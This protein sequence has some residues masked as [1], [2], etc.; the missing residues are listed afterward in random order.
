[1]CYGRVVYNFPRL[2]PPVRSPRFVVTNLFTGY[3]GLGQKREELY[4]FPLHKAV[5]RSTFSCAK[6]YGPPC[7]TEM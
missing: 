1:M 6:A 7:I 2:H 3:K 5:N 4:K